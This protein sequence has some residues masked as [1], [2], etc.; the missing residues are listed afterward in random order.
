M[1]FYWKIDRKISVLSID[2]LK[3][4]IGSGNI[5]E[6]IPSHL[7]HDIGVFPF[8]DTFYGP[9]EV[10]PMKDGWWNI[11]ALSKI[12]D[13]FER[14]TTIDRSKLSQAFYASQQSDK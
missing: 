9:I 14:I 7:P 13:A 12:R 1:P 10:L 11:P 2:Y 4:P 6:F 3:P 8:Q 5:L